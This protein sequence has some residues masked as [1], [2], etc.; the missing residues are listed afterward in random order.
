MILARDQGLA[1]VMIDTLD[2]LTQ[3]TFQ[4]PG[5][6]RKLV[7]A[8]VPVGINIYLFPT[9]AGRYC[10]TSFHFA[11]FDFTS[12]GAPECFQVSAG[13][14]SYSGTLA[15]RVQDGRPVTHQAMDLQG[16][17]VLLGERYPSV[18]RQFPAPPPAQ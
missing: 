4:P 6:G 2:P 14:L 12:R 13:Q 15:P 8:Q 18:A 5:G 16:F 7:V 3:V 9:R 10:M 1:A 17:R 11:S